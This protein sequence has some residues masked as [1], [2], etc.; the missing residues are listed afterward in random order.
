MELTSLIGVL[1]MLKMISI[2]MV[3]HLF[4]AKSTMF[5]AI[6]LQNESRLV[7]KSTTPVKKNVQEP[8]ENPNLGDAASDEEC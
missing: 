1:T 5:S 4:L 7:Y 6:P 8:V 2:L 3:N